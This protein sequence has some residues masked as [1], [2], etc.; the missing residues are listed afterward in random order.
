MHIFHLGVLSSPTR[1]KYHLK[2]LKVKQLQKLEPR[3]G[4]RFGFDWPGSARQQ[5]T[6]WVSNLPVF[7]IPRRKPPTP[8]VSAHARI[9]VTP[10]AAWARERERAS[11]GI[12]HLVLMTRQAAR[13]ER[14][15]RRARWQNKS[16]FRSLG[17]ITSRVN[18]RYL[19]YDPSTANLHYC[20]TCVL[21]FNNAKTWVFSL[22]LTIL[23]IYNS[24]WLCI[25]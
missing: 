17:R 18:L 11:G 4:S 21:Y 3:S 8:R 19:H 14:A 25:Y 16:L 10:G 2:C 15:A 23:F 7:G 1:R 9:C 24:V 13:G 6:L 20:E 5:W 22:L 12:S